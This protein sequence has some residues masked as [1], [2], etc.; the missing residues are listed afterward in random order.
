[1]RE[2]SSTLILPGSQKTPAACR[3]CH[4][5]FTPKTVRTQFCSR[6]CYHAWYASPESFW[7][8][9]DQTGECW[10]WMR[11]KKRFGHGAA[12][13]DGQLWQASRLA[14]TLAYGPIPEGFFACHHCDNP[15]CCRPSHLFLGTQADNIADMVAKGRY[16]NIMLAHPELAARGDANGSRKHPERVARGERQGCARLTEIHVLAIRA[17]LAA[18][19]LTKAQLARQY[20]VAFMTITCIERR[21]TWTHI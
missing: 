7:S 18:H 17:A 15:P 12:W 19:E 21:R 9:V 5:L 1:M 4:Q 2:H 10:P 20:G 14:W 3:Q 8:K 16:R 11:S 6:D 13:F